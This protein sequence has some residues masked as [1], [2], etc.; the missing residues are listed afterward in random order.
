MINLFLPPR[1]DDVGA[2]RYNHLPSRDPSGSGC[3]LPFGNPSYL[4]QP[5]NSRVPRLHRQLPY[6]HAI[7]SH[8]IPQPRKASHES[9][10]PPHIP[11][12]YGMRQ[13]LYLDPQKPAAFPQILN[14]PARRS[15]P[16]LRVPSIHI[17]PQFHQQRN[18]LA[19]ALKRRV[20]QRRRSRPVLDTHKFRMARK[21]CPDPLAVSALRS[22][23]QLF[24][25]SHSNRSSVITQNRPAT[26]T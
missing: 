26:I 7:R 13:I 21:N 12:P 23:Y 1:S 24:D 14:S 25:F 2:M 10:R 8:S 15:R 3:L 5:R 11:R 20:V 19:P 22:L 6:R 16:E 18:N 17:R 4:K 9:L